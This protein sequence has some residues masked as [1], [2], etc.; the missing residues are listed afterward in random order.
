MALFIS[1][2][3]ALTFED[4]LLERNCSSTLEIGEHIKSYWSSQCSNPDIS[5]VKQAPTKPENI[6]YLILPRKGIAH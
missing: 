4:R 1:Y 2:E 5:V 6:S 3:G